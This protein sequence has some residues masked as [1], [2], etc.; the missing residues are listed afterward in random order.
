MKK[1]ILSLLFILLLIL[2]GCQSLLPDDPAHN[3]ALLT[4]PDNHA[5][6]HKT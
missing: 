4:D 1:S 6:Y 2:C 5:T 3:A